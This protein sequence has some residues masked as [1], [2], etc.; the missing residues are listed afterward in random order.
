MVDCLAAK[1]RQFVE[2]PLG[3]LEISGINPSVN[4]P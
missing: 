4:Q 3:V 2:Q 1:L